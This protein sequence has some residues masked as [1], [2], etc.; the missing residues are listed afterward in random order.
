[1]FY[2]KHMRNITVI[3]IKVLQL[4]MRLKIRDRYKESQIF[5]KGGML[6]HPYNE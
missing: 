3:L 6:S 2:L 1:M 4:Y 5:Y